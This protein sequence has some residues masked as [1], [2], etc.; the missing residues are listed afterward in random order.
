M[1]DVEFNYDR[2]ANGLFVNIIYFHDGPVSYFGI[3]FY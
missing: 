3:D 1:H 2:T